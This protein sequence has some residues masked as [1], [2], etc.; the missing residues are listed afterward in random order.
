MPVEIKI[1]A[2]AAHEALHELHQLANGLSYMPNVDG[3][4]ERVVVPPTVVTESGVD[5]DDY[6]APSGDEALD[7]RPV[8]SPSEGKS[9]RNSNEKAEDDELEA[10]VT[11]K[12]VTL[13][14][15]NAAISKAGRAEA[16]AQ[17][18]ALGE[19]A[20]DKP[21]ISSGE[22]RS[23]PEDDPETEAQDAADEQAEVEENRDDEAPLTIDD[24]KSAM[25]AYVS[26]HDMA[27]AQEDG[28]KI[29]V[30]ALGKPPAGEEFW[31]ASLVASSG[32]DHLKK[33]IDAWNAAA[34]AGKRY[35][36]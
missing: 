22:N 2:E 9:R 11:E 24:L 30:A 5:T 17:L 28:P 4:K 18:E 8:G 26:A 34:A 23:G 27:A 29:F 20:D 12:R 21:Q 31:K 36:V 16:R 10:L 33:A 35:G 6:K 3:P 7:T 32:Q 13:D 15:L 19:E 14:Q 1:Y 25:G